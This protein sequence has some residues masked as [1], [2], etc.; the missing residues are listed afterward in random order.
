MPYS[1]SR[2]CFFAGALGAIPI[3]RSLDAFIPATVEDSRSEAAFE[4]RKRAAL[5]QSKRPI[6]SMDTNGDENALPKRIACF[7][8]GLPRNQFGEV[9]TATYEALL[10]AIRS[11]KHPDFERIPRG[12]GRKLS[13]P[14]AAFAFHLE[15][16]DPHTFDIPRAP[17]ITSEAAA[18][19][20]CELYWQSLCRDV[21]FL[22]YGSSPVIREAAAHLG[23]PVSSVF[24]GPTKAHWQGPY[25]SQFLLKPI[26][27]GSAK[28]E[29]RYSAPLSG[30]DFV[31]ALSEWSQIQTGMSPWREASYDTTP[32]YIRNGRDLAEYVHYDFPYQAYLN[33]ALILI[34]SG[35]KSILNCNQFKS[36]SNPYRYSTEEDG[37]VTFGQ[38]EVTDW[39][40][41]VTTAALKAAYFQKWTVHRRLRPEEL[42]GLVH[43]TRVGTR[44]HPVHEALRNSPAVDAVFS[45]TGSYLLPQA[46]PEGSPL[47]PSY[48]SGHATIAGACSVVLKACFDGSMLLPGC[49][50]PSADGMSLTP[51]SGYSPTVGDEID[52]L[53]FNIAMGRNWAGI[54]Y[55][56]DDNAG[57]RLGEDVGISILQDLA[58]TYTEDFRGFSFKRFNGTEVQITPRGE[59]VAAPRKA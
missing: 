56:S 20:G 40:G 54:H 39:L 49:V 34:N 30:S 32:R 57:L 47:H 44:E 17:S 5:L 46:Y 14:Q 53:A 58:C 10:V 41:R 50:E 27:Y 18:W 3:S 42:G 13:N 11:Q 59:V 51:C 19:E 45:R 15:G 25:V 43:Q 48:P 8:K 1:F 2:R 38:A 37:F 12:G 28:I 6:A 7:T 9:E 35:P 29:Q 26:P 16:G 24:R 31:S 33:A 52:K 21:P 23:S 36:D 55:R 4:L 22:A